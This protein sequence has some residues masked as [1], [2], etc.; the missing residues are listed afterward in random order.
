MGL[1]MADA[2]LAAG[3]ADVRLWG[4][5]GPQVEELQSKRTNADRLQGFTL[6][7]AIEV[8][9]D[10]AVALKGASIVLHAIP[11]QVTAEAWTTLAPH[12][13]TDA[14]VASTAKGIEVGTRRLPS[15]ILRDVIGPRA[16]HAVVSGPTIATELARRQPAVMVAAAES[17]SVSERL[18]QALHCPWLRIYSST[19]VIG[20]ELSGAS[21]NVIAIA[22]GI[23]D[24]LQLGDN[25]KSAVLARGL[26]E[27]TRLGVAMGAQRAT[28]FG[29]AGVGDLATTCFS[30]HGR[31]RS[32][33]E[34]LG[35]GEHQ[36]EYLQRTGATVEGIDTARSLAELAQEADVEMPIAQAIHDVLFDDVEVRDAFDQLMARD[37]GAEWA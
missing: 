28:F 11:V 36:D 29:I 20:V 7:P 3:P 14:I 15:R 12:L 35:R 8:T 21:K 19:D 33:G 30:P 37:M 13:D 25:A 27:I 17:E 32:F 18:Q 10:P 26:A 9:D 16:I 31:N 34:A 4:P 5:P 1:V 6:D 24:G 23:C 2:A 22:A